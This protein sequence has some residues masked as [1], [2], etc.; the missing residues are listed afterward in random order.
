MTTTPCLTLQKCPTCGTNCR[1]TLNGEYVYTPI[2]LSVEELAKV[3]LDADMKEMARNNDGKRQ[4][5]EDYKMSKLCSCGHCH[6]AFLDATAI[7]RAVY[8]GKNERP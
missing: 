7:H 8:G 1:K 2:H 3:I 6:R 5:K 4:H